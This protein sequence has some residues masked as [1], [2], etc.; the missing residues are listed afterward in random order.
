MDNA[1]DMLFQVS[2]KGLFF[3]NEQ[4]VMM[5]QEDDGTWEF[6]GGRVQKGEDLVEGLQ[7]EC[8]GTR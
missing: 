7:R 5:I 4:K 8:S 1:N 3:D 6:P 2:V